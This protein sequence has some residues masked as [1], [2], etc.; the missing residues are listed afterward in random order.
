MGINGS[1]MRRVMNAHTDPGAFLGFDVQDY[2]TAITQV[3]HCQPAIVEQQ[4]GLCKIPKLL[5][6]HDLL[7]VITSQK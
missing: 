2:C 6:S 4:S 5:L 3:T 1:K 7:L